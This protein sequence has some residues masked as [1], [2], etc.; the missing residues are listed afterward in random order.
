MDSRLK[1]L[2]LR[3]RIALLVLVLLAEAVSCCDMRE[4][5]DWEGR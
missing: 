2:T 3:L 5:K 4:S 1:G